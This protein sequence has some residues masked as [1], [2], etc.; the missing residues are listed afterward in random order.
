[1]G[2][3]YAAAYV[4]IIAAVGCDPEHGLP[5]VKPGSRGKIKSLIMDKVRLS[6]LPALQNLRDVSKSAWVT[7]GWTFQEGFLS[8]RR[9][10]FCTNQVVFVCNSQMYHESENA[11]FQGEH[12]A[13]RPG[14]LPSTAHEEDAL[15][16]AMSCLDTYTRRTLSFEGDSLNAIVGA[17]NTFRTESVYHIWGVPF[18]GAE[19]QSTATTETEILTSG[20]ALFWSHEWRCTRRRDFPSWSPVGWEGEIYWLNT[21]TGSH[22]RLMADLRAIVVVT[23]DSEHNMY[24]L[25]TSQKELPEVSRFI[26]VSVRSAPLRLTASDTTPGYPLDDEAHSTDSEELDSIGILIPF[27]DELQV[28]I[29]VMWDVLPSQFKAG[30]LIKGVLIPRVIGAKEERRDQG[31]CILLLERHGQH[32]ERIGVIII[33]QEPWSKESYLCRTVERVPIVCGRNSMPLGEG[34]E[35]TTVKE[36]IHATDFWWRQTFT[37]DETI[38]LG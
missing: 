6:I 36:R 4:T 32:Y 38:I 21:R 9:L 15:S 34:D 1:M 31:E 8:R 30:E 17:L 20:L 24:S 14:W 37:N 35:L 22:T 25:G 26:Y 5:G 10:I 18:L 19:H 3:I 16:R 12:N 11:D 13:W 27:D 2:D 33:P 28:I 29:D 7:R 23:P